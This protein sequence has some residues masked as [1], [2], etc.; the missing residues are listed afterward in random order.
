M[1]LVDDRE[2]SR[3]MMAL[4][5]F[6]IPATQIRLDSGDCYF[7][8]NGPP[9]TTPYQIGFER[10]KLDDL[11]NCMKDRRLSG[12]QLRSMWAVYDKVY[13]VVEGLWKP[14][15]GGSIQVA[16]GGGWR[17]MYHRG[18]GV[19]YRQ[20]DAYLSSLAECGGVEI[21]HSFSTDHTAQIYVSRYHWWQKPYNQHRSHDQIYQPDPTLQR[22]GR[23][24]LHTGTPSLA[25]LWAAAIPGMDSKAWDVGRQFDSAYDLATAGVDRWRQVTWTANTVNGQAE[26]RIGKKA[27][28]D[29][30]AAVHGKGRNGNGDGS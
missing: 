4:S 29:I 20:V 21:L 26:R 7:T 17:D 30:V 14:S 19:S 27:A 1:I 11:I 18:A 5:A 16:T 15:P 22:R 9:S 10:K 23:A 2:E 3:L 8:G 24:V 6:D 12:A 28:A 13:L 25:V